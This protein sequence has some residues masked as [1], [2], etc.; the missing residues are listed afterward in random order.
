MTKYDLNTYGNH[1][2][3][4][5][6]ICVGMTEVNDLCS[7]VTMDYA[8]KILDTFNDKTMYGLRDAISSRMQSVQF[9]NEILN[10]IHHID[11]KIT[12]DPNPF[13]GMQLSSKQ[14]H[15][16]D[17]IV[18][19]SVSLYDYISCFLSYIVFNRPKA[20]WSSIANSARS[21]DDFKCFEVAKKIDELDRSV[22]AKLISYRGD[23]IH[24]N[25]DYTPSDQSFSLTQ[26]QGTIAVFCPSNF[27][28]RF[29]KELGE[30]NAQH[31]NPVAN[32]LIDNLVQGTITLLNEAR[33]Y[34]EL[35]RVVKPGDEF[36][37]FVKPNG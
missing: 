24:Y 28:I 7:L 8:R 10:S 35:N 26:N 5:E 20:Q 22:V 37:T 21:N 25:D 4:F 31:I 30:R 12:S 16:F 29:K 27:S 2:N 33:N 36:I 14:S 34:I 3:A 6:K 18:F 1:Q 32:W 13:I 19:H 23:L 15:I 17:S 9:H 11:R